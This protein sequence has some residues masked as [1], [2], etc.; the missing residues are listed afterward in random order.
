MKA[1]RWARQRIAGPPHPFLGPYLPAMAVSLTTLNLAKTYGHHHLFE[2]ISLALDHRERL[3]LIGPNGSGKSTLLKILAGIETADEGAVSIRKGLR[4]AYV[5]QS[6]VFPAGSTVLSA[7]VDGLKGVTI[8]SIHDEHERELHAELVLR[9][10]GFEDLGLG[11]PE[12]DF[13]MCRRLRFRGGRGS[14]WRLRGS[15]RRSRTF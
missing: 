9:R 1:C 3:A 10:L 5:A 7:V 11:G 13:C 2:G 15:W 8:A 12:H 6:D 4:P 14:G